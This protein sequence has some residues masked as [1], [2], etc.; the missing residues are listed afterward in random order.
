MSLCL[1]E[2]LFA[3]TKTQGG[4]AYVRGLI[5]RDQAAQK[6]IFTVPDESSFGEPT[7]VNMPCTLRPFYEDGKT[8]MNHL[9]FIPMDTAPKD[10]SE[11]LC[12]A[13]GHAPDF[14]EGSR[15]YELV[16]WISAT[17]SRPGFWT[18]R[19]AEEH[20][21]EYSP[22]YDGLSPQ[23]ELHGWM[24]LPDPMTIEMPLRYYRRSAASEL[25]TGVPSTEETP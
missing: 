19:E 4:S 15:R 20:N 18:T 6:R 16:Y 23:I 13:E 11:F 3:W 12:I 10:G 2:S 1:P 14:E 17:K 7:T 5:E 21:S 25:L 8:I 24:A 9:N 22:D